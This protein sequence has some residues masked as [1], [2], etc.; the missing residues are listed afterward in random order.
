MGNILDFGQNMAGVV[1]FTVQGAPGDTIRLRYAE[2]L[3]KDGSLYRDNLRNALSEDIYICNG[4]EKGKSSCALFV[5]HGFRYVEVTGLKTFTKK[6]FTAYTISDDLS[7]SAW[8]APDSMLTCFNT[9]DTILNKVLRNAWWGIYSN[10]KGMPVDCPQR[11]ER[12]P[13]LGDRTAGCLGESYLFD[14]ERL[15]SKWM[16]DIQDSQRSDGCISN[17]SPSFWN[18]YEDNMTWPAVFPFACDMLYEQYGNIQPVKDAYPALRKWLDHI[19]EEYESHGII[20]KDKYGDWCVPPEKLT[21]IH[22]LD[23]ARQTDGETDFHGVWYS[24]FAVDGE[25]CPIAASFC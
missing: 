9:S 5:Y 13:W 15:Y 10:Y 22:S 11:N 3:K 19:F 2:K 18:Y 17:V 12:Q 4:K 20:T 1:R 24:N 6:D 7:S 23:P 25:I 16:H 21:L 8:P 14:N